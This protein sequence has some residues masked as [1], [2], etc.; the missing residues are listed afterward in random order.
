MPE[1]LSDR[2][3]AV[4]RGVWMGLSDREIAAEVIL[5]HSTVKAHM[6]IILA[7]LGLRNRAEVAVWYE[8][9]VKPPK[10]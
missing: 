4:A 7:K 3:L 6:R 10:E 1:L 2:E 9:E 8:R 5:A